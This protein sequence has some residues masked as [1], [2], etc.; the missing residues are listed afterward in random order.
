MDTETKTFSSL[1]DGTDEEFK[2]Y[3]SSLSLG[4]VMSLR[5]LISGSYTTIEAAKDKVIS[6]FTEKD[7]SDSVKFKTL[8]DFYLAMQNLEN[9]ATICVQRVQEIQS[10]G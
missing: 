8:Q 10:A 1:M 9:K 5:K 4:E 6:E 3:C 2:A 7:A